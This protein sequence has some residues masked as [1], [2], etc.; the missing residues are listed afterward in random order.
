MH[1]VQHFGSAVLTASMTTIGSAVP[2]GR[3]LVVKAFTVANDTG[4]V[5]SLKIQVTFTSGGTPRVMVPDRNVA[6]N[7]TDLIPE[8]INHVIDPGGII[9]AQGLNLTVAVSGVL[10]N[11]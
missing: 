3:K 2:T 4:G 11:A 7:D 6:D 1:T 9:E 8:L 5:V 10:V